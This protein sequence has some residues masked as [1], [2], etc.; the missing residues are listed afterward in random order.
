MTFVFTFILNHNY[1]L[2]N[3]IIGFMGYED[4]N[5]LFSTSGLRICIV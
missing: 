1:A 3:S 2:N 5:V 4:D